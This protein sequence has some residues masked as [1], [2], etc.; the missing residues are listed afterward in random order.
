MSAATSPAYTDL[1]SLSGKSALVTGGGMGIGL[2]TARRLAEAGAQV[3]VVDLDGA[4]AQQAAQSLVGPAQHRHLKLDVTSEGAAQIAVS[5]CVDAFGRIDVLVNNAGIYPLESLTEATS[6]ILDRTYTINVRSCILFAQ[7]CAQAMIEQGDGG[8]IINVASIE[9]Y[10][11]AAVGFAGYGA[12]KGAIVSFTKHAAL[13][14]APSGITVNA[15]APGP[16][17]T[18]GVSSLG[19]GTMGADHG[20]LLMNKF[21]SRI[22]MGR[23]AAPDDIAMPVL[24]LASAAAAYITG[25][26]LLIDGGNILS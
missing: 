22:P 14:L 9:A 16:V 26:T 19:A 1:L 3:L 11:P 18:E 23:L 15:V 2:A 17:A 12:T 8:R 5:E 13:E 10:H 7:A 21:L 6:P 25:E 20:Q 24:F 4:H